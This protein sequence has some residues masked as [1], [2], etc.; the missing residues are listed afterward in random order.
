MTSTRTQPAPPGRPER[1]TTYTIAVQRGC[2]PVAAGTVVRAA[3]FAQAKEEAFALFL[4]CGASSGSVTI[5]RG[6]G[7]KIEWIGSFG[8]TPGQE[9]RWEAAF[10]TPSADRRYA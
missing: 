5:G 1:K 8:F 9:P 3:S 2:D 4:G 7:K 6:E 10:D